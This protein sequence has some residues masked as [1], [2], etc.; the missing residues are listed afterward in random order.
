MAAVVE[1]LVVLAH[2]QFLHPDAAVIAEFLQHGQHTTNPKS[3][4]ARH[5]RRHQDGAAVEGQRAEAPRYNSSAVQQQ[6]DE[7]LSET[8]PR[9]TETLPT[10]ASTSSSSTT[11]HESSAKSSLASVVASPPVGRTTCDV[12][13]GGESGARGRGCQNVGEAGAGGRVGGGKDG[14]DVPM[15]SPTRGGRGMCLVRQW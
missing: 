13:D 1:A 6:R 15:T 9:P 7:G 14:E 12:P 11:D 3:S 5:Q 10:D 4:E 2:G 8:V